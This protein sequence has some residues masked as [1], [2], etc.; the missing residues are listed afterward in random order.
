MSDHLLNILNQEL[1][2]INVQRVLAEMTDNKNR[3][4]YWN[5]KRHEVLVALRIR[6]RELGIYGPVYEQGDL[7]ADVPFEVVKPEE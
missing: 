2:H 4:E 1:C 5:A 7:F 6:Q 3:Q